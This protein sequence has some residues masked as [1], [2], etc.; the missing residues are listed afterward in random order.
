MT[1]AIK[2]IAVIL[3]GLLFWVLG[4]TALDVPAGLPWWRHGLGAIGIVCAVH[5]WP[6]AWKR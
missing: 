4:L 1:E 3:S 2:S 6:A 5:I